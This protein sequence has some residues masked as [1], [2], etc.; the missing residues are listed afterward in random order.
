VD[1]VRFTAD[2]TVGKLAHWMSLLGYDIIW[3][4]RSAREIID[5]RRAGLAASG[6]QRLVLGRS[7][8]LAE[9]PSMREEFVP[10]ESP[11]LVQQIRQAMQAFPMDFQKTLFTRCT[12]CNEILGGLLP[13][14][15]IRIEL[16]LLVR[17]YGSDFRRCPSCGQLY[18]RGT[19]THRILEFLRDEVGLDV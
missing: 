14:E 15:K 13:L 18:W 19:H 16:P 9:D 10:I 3:D 4:R 11:Y 8:T 1:T 2:N 7:P 6:P 12:H 17:E 5:A